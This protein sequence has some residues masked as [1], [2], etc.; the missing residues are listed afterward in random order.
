M[1]ISIFISVSIYTDSSAHAD[2]A[3]LG[4]I[5]HLLVMENFLLFACSQH[6]GQELGEEMFPKILISS[7]K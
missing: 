3:W 6:C 2:H 5:C 4:E 1:F 7:T